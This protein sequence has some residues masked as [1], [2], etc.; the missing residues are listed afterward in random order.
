MPCFWKKVDIW[1]QVIVSSV[2]TYLEREDI[3]LC[4][5]VFLETRAQQMACL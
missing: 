3:E 5:L 4:Q 2:N 1:V